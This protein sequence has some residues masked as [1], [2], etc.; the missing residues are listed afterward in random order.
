MTATDTLVE[1]HRAERPV[2]SGRVGRLPAVEGEIVLTRG[3]SL[4]VSRGWRRAVPPSWRPDGTAPSRR[5]SAARCLVFDHFE[6]GHRVLLDDGKFEGVVRDWTTTGVA[7]RLCA[8]DRGVRV[9]LAEKG[10]NSSRH[11]ALD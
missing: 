3:D 6:I 11:G 7:S 10:M 1:L 2:D 4:V 9:L 8:P 5:R